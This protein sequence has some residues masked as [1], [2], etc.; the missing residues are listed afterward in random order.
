MA[1]RE[2]WVFI[3]CGIGLLGAGAWINIYCAIPGFLLTL[4]FVNFFRDPDRRLPAEDGVVSPADGRV[5]VIQEIDPAANSGYSLFISIFMNVFDV[6][7][8][9]APIAGSIT[10]YQHFQGKFLPAY[11]ERAP[12]EN[13]RN[14]I[15]IVN[16]SFK[17]KLSQVAGLI[18]R[19]IVFK[20]KTGDV[21]KRGERF[22]MIRFGSRV[23][24]WLPRNFETI[25]KSGDKVYAGRT[26]L[27]KMKV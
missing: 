24:L 15:T 9:R 21:L 20:R 4:F 2:G 25:V 23:D 27:A 11:E 17:I 1:I 7:V 13:E 18:A 3:A 10:E 19:R 16:E 12:F 22:G 5:I 8:N 26:L 14:E 6:H